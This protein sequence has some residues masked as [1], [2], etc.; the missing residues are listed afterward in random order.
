[1][2]LSPPWLEALANA[3]SRYD[4]VIDPGV[5]GVSGPRNEPGSHHGVEGE[6]L[7]LAVV[8]R[9]EHEGHVVAR[10]HL[11]PHQVSEARPT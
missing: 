1:M 8:H 9:S 3:F 6:Q 4:E 10:C 7:H 2:S 11:P 5:G